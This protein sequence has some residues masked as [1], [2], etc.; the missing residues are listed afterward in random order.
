MFF[1]RVNQHVWPLQFGKM[2][3]VFSQGT[4]ATALTGARE[5]SRCSHSSMEAIWNSVCGENIT[6]FPLNTSWWNVTSHCPGGRVL[7]F[8]IM[9]CISEEHIC[10]PLLTVQVAL[11]NNAESRLASCKPR[12][13]LWKST[14]ARNSLLWSKMCVCVCRT[15]RLLLLDTLFY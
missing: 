6:S 4:L 8:P 11:R 10:A 14:A 5:G 13:Y 2:E 7:T 3:H 15:W 12:T 1:A 9:M